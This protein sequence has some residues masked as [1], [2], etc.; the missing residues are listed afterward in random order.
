MIQIQQVINKEKIV[1]HGSLINAAKNALRALNRED[2]ELTIRLTGDDEMA[3]LNQRFRNI[4]Q[5]TDVLSFT[6]EVVDPETGRTYLGD[7]IVSLEQASKQ[8]NEHNLTL[9]E[10]CIYLV[11]HGTLHLLGYDHKNL[12]E[13]K[14]MWLLQEQLFNESIDKHEETNI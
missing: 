7:V 1:N 4:D 9:E 11:I 14:K 12:D 8:A 2:S 3:A 13:K 5:T 10:E 6:Q